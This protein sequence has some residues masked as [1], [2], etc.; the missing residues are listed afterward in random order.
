MCLWT[1]VYLSH[2]TLRTPM[3]VLPP[4]AQALRI[5]LPMHVQIRGHH[6]PRLSKTAV[7]RSDT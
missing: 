1:I 7:R 6:N 5:I 3:V 2:Q 4:L